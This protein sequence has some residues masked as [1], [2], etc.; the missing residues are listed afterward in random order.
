MLE[1]ECV[2]EAAVARE[3][4]STRLARADDASDAYPEL[5]DALADTRDLWPSATKLDTDRP[6]AD[7]ATAARGLVDA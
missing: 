7:V 3:R 6:V 5:V 1:I 4:I 2:L